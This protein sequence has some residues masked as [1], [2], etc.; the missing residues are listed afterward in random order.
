MSQEAK[1]IARIAENLP[2]EKDGLDSTT[3]QGWIDNPKALQEALKRTLCPPVVAKVIK[4]LL[5]RRNDVSLPASSETF[6]PNVSFQ[7]RPGL[8]VWD[9]FRNRIVAATK[10]IRSVAETKIGS[11][12]L[13]IASN[14]AEIRAELPENHVFENPS[15]FCA[16]LA[17]MIQHQANGQAGELLSN[18]YANIFYVL[19][20]NGEVFDVFVVWSAD[21]REWSVSTY[22]L[23]VLRWNAGR[24]AFSS[25]C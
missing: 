9:E 14:D 16:R 18:G 7:T 17:G 10:T 2:S 6:D 5:R 4:H 19:G 8:Y 1:L 12:D 25:N 24:R 23:D 22:E 3:R 13:V 15:E 11:F 21:D 20:Q